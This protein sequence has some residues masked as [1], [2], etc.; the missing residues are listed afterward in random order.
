MAVFVNGSEKEDRDSSDQ[1]ERILSALTKRTKNERE[2][3]KIIDGSIEREES[4]IELMKGLLSGM[5]KDSE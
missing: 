2:N 3:Q 4:E 5:M 1:M